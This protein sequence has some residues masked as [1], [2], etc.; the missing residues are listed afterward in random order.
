L[1]FFTGNHSSFITGKVLEQP[2]RAPLNDL[3]KQLR[4]TSMSPQDHNKTLVLIY[5]LLGG[6]FTVPLIAS[7]WILA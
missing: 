3:N 6:L 7:P 5:S 2:R 4:R 1:P